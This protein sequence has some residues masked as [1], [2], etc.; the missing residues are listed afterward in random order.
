[1]LI[2]TLNTGILLGYILGRYFIYFIFPWVVI[3]FPVI[4]MLGFSFVPETPIWLMKHKRI[5][6]AEQSLRFYRGISRDQ[7]EISKEFNE[8]LEQLKHFAEIKTVLETK[9]NDLHFRDFGK[10]LQ[11]VLFQNR[12]IFLNFF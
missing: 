9:E 6:E 5:N 2:L 4:F 12:I 3:G 10:I 11:I 7:I 1:M 8:E